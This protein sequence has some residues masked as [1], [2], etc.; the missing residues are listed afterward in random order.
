[1]TKKKCTALFVAVCMLLTLACMLPLMQNVSAAGYTQLEQDDFSKITNGT[2][3][4]PGGTSNPGN[5]KLYYYSNANS[6]N[7]P[8]VY[9]D[10]GI[11]ITKSAK[12]GNVVLYKD[13]TA[14]AVTTG[15][16]TYSFDAKFKN[17]VGSNQIYWEDYFLRLGAN[18][19]ADRTNAQGLCYSGIMAK[20]G[21]VI[22]PKGGAANQSVM[23]SILGSEY[24]NHHFVYTI[25]YDAGTYSVMVNNTAITSSGKTE[26]PIPEDFLANGGAK[27]FM[28]N[29]KLQ[30]VSTID[31]FVLELKNFKVTA[32]ETM[33]PEQNA[34]TVTDITTSSATL[35]WHPLSS[36]GVTGYEIYCDDALMATIADGATTSYTATALS[37]GTNYT[38]SVKPLFAD[39]RSYDS[40]PFVSLSTSG[41]AAREGNLIQIAAGRTHMLGINKNERVHGVGN[42]SFGQ[43]SVFGKATKAVAAGHD[44]SYAIDE[45]GKLFAWGNNYAG[46]LGIGS[47]ALMQKTPTEVRGMTDVVAVSA[48]AEHALAQTDSG[49]VYAWGD[50]RYGQLGTQNSDT[51]SGVN[52]PV[53]VTA[54]SGKGVVSV[55][56]GKYTSYAVCSDGSL[57][58]WGMNYAGQLG[59]G[60]NALDNKDVPILISVPDQ[61]VLAVS[62]GGGHVVALCYSD[63]NGNNAYDEY[64]TKSVWGWGSNTRAQLGTGALGKW[65]NTPTRLTF[66]DDKHIT[67]LSAGEGHTLALDA[68]GVVYAW[69]W[70]ENGQVGSGG[71]EFGLAPLVMQ[72]L[73]AIRTVAAG[74]AHSV[75]VG[76][77]GS[78]WGWGANGENQIDA[79]A[80]ENY[81]RPVKIQLSLSNILYGAA[82]FGST[83]S[84]PAIGGTQDFAVS[85]Y[86]NG[87]KAFDGKVL[88]C[89]YKEENGNSELLGAYP[90]EIVLEVEQETTVTKQITLPK[91]TENVY[92]KVFAWDKNLAPYSESCI[93]R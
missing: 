12:G 23:Q 38:F 93:I 88:I 48:G 35:S 55:T 16:V 90:T 66:F 61:K 2:L 13:M 50:N 4:T 75:A 71:T 17:P 3:L 62:A 81:F 37:A 1:M 7:D 14:T 42:N 49:D 56:A 22:M 15:K 77:D 10:G 36:V 60:D 58:A 76:F 69:G 83:E 47:T 74:Y 39:S 84:V 53:L 21:M 89:V 8:I 29:M 64:E 63:S 70:N 68:E 5:W 52:A 86:N 44:S 25:D 51:V 78:L 19:P 20:A 79:S 33:W 11:R 59:N 41:F 45:N 67:A 43:L 54:L 24:K 18:V 73:P 92:V 6:T 80:T 65:Y 46:Q 40:V 57:Y 26:F 34:L 28:I 9:Q 27:Y 85:V 31:D 72:N 30:S 32:G 87:E 91:T 82:G